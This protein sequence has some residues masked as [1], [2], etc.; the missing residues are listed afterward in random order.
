ML[1]PSFATLF[2]IKWTD[3]VFKFVRRVRHQLFGEAKNFFHV[4]A[5]SLYL[6]SVSGTSPAI[7]DVSKVAGKSFWTCREIFACV[8]KGLGRN[9]CFRLQRNPCVRLGRN[10]CLLAR[11]LLLDHWL[12]SCLTWPPFT[13]NPPQFYANHL[14]QI[15]KFLSHTKHL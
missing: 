9:I 10:T 13:T 7:R 12:P 5:R 3:S 2:L 6:A 15:I 8:F 4:F 1:S 14:G 11:L